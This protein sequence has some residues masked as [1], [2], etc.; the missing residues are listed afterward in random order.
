MPSCPLFVHLAYQWSFLFVC[1]VGLYAGHPYIHLISFEIFLLALILYIVHYIT[2]S[3]AQSI[4]S[5]Y[6]IIYS[7][8]QSCTVNTQSS[9]FLSA[10]AMM[11]TQHTHHCVLTVH[12]CVSTVH[13]CVLTVHHCVSTVHHCVL[14][15]YHYRLCITVFD[16]A[17]LCFDCVSL[18]TVY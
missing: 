12:H 10:Q 17:S 13:H 4:H 18:L 1:I 14:T 3:D 15:V 9:I 8:T 11:L 7:A 2:A 6:I 16:C 5:E